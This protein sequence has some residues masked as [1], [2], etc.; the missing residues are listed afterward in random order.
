MS[1]V[2]LKAQYFDEWM[3]RWR[4]YQAVSDWEIETRSQARRERNYLISG[5]LSAAAGFYTMA[6]STV[7]RV[8]GEINFFDNGFD[9]R[10]KNSIRSFLNGQRR[11]TP[12]GYLRIASIIAPG[13][14]AVVGLER[15]NENKR[16]AEYLRQETVFGEQARRYEKSG[17][18][19][20][21]FAINIRAPLPEADRCVLPKSGDECHNCGKDLQVA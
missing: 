6:P 1:K 7:N 21:F 14:V 3:I 9:S 4:R 11:W 8:F 19:E 5:T 18:I 17:K 2:E 15:L 10:I 16:W 12:N 20:E 13:Y